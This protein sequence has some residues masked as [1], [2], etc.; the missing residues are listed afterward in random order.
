[1]RTVIF[2]TATAFAV[3]A[4]AAG[5]EIA[6]QPNC[7][8]NLI[9][10]PHYSDTIAPLPL[11]NADDSLGSKGSASPAALTKGG[12]PSTPASLTIIMAEHV[13]D[14]RK[15][16]PNDVPSSGGGLAPLINNPHPTP[17]YLPLPGSHE[18][19]PIRIIN[20]P[21]FDSGCASH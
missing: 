17:S 7:D 3:M 13:T 4:S 1:M 11:L 14:S 16:L 18:V 6:L 19:N 5:I 2:A 20:A 15:P 21:Q 9:N 12:V 10:E 8:V